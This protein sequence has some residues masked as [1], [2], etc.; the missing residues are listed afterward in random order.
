MDADATFMEVCG[1]ISKENSI[2]KNGWRVVPFFEKC[3]NCWRVVGVIFF[4]DVEMGVEMEWSG[5]AM[6]KQGPH[7]A[8]E[9]FLR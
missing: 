4:R 5:C 2:P 8:Y 3:V 9:I 1:R 6:R 7:L